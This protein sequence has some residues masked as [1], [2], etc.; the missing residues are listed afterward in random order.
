MPAEITSPIVLPLKRG[1]APPVRLEDPAA[2]SEVMPSGV[3]GCV[4]VILSMLLLSNSPRYRAPGP[5]EP[6]PL[7]P[8]V[9]FMQETA[10]WRS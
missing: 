3:D 8:G 2:K 5:V 1:L 9:N 6:H 7:K 4:P 10:Q